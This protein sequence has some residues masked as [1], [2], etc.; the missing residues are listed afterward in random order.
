MNLRPATIRRIEQRAFDICRAQ[1]KPLKR[2]LVRW[3]RSMG[4]FI[5]NLWNGKT[6]SLA[7]HYWLFLVVPG[8][9]FSVLGKAIEFTSLSFTPTSFGVVSGILAT[10]ALIVFVIGYVGLINCARFRGFRGWAAVAV[11]VTTLSLIGTIAG[12]VAEFSG[13]P[14]NETKQLYDAARAINVQTP[15]KI[16]AITTLTKAEYGDDVFTYYYDIDPAGYQS[17]TWSV[18]RLKETIKKNACDTFKGSLGTSVLR[19]VRYVYKTGASG[20]IVIEIGER[21]CEPAR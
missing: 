21:D 14:L 8:I 4:Q 19:N 10:F 16:D 2:Q 18:D 6:F 12:V 9:V 7:K 11:I 20:N 13:T 3:R 1:R 17:P 5:A 15:K